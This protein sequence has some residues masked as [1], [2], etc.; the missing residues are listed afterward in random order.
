MQPQDG[1]LLVAPGQVEDE[2][3]LG[4]DV[5]RLL[6][7]EDDQQIDLAVAQP[8]R[9]RALDAVPR[10]AAAAVDLAALDREVDLRAARI[11][12][13]KLDLGAEH[14]AQ[15]HREIVEVGARPFAPERERLG[16][17][18]RP[19]LDRRGVPGRAQAR[20]AGDAAQPGEFARVELQVA[21]QRLDRDT[22]RHGAD[23][24]AVLGGDRKDVVRRLDTAGARHV[25][26]DDGRTAG[27]VLADVAG[28]GAAA[29]GG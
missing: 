22:A 10:P 19:G 1:A 12:G 21:E 6:Q 2:R 7:R 28:R 24:R 29:Q 9:A 13:H 14:G 5:G 18:V 25:L 15:D 23:Y 17:H 26:R 4:R 3:H 8:V 20:G 27:N 16:E 11:A